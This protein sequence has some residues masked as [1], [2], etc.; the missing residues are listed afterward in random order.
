MIV[1]EIDIMERTFPTRDGHYKF[2]VMPFGL[3]S[4]VP[5]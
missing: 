3:M 4:P 5:L 2:M 1:N